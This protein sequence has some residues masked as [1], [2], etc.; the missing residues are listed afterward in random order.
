MILCGR[1]CP[2]VV[3]G[4]SARGLALAWRVF[5]GALRVVVG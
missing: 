1:A 4:V 2:G 5:W 3:C